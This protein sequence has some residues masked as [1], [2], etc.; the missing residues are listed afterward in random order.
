MVMTW[1]DWIDYSTCS[2]CHIC[3][4]HFKHGD[5]KIRDHDHATGKYRGVA[6]NKC[7][8]TYLSNRYLP[9]V[10]HNLKGYARHLIIK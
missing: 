1:K 8:I 9:V 3:T 2:N 10:F 4:K 6:H 5:V 7:N